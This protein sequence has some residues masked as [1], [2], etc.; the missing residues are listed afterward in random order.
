MWRADGLGNSEVFRLCQ[1]L[2][3]RL[4]QMGHLRGDHHG[5]HVLHVCSD[6][7]AEKEHHHHWH[8]EE[9]QH[10]THV[11]QDM[12][13]FLDYKCYKLFHTLNRLNGWPDG[14]DR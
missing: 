14:P 6:G 5:A 1:P 11:A 2:N 4:R 13:G 10:R 12:L 3:S 8:S 7:E 9:Y